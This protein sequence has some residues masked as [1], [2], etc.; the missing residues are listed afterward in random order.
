MFVA[1]FTVYNEITH[2]FESF[3]DYHED[4]YVLNER[5]KGRLSNPN[6]HL[7]GFYKLY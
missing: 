6:W 5:V 3:R 2:K 4:V 7:T 1:Q